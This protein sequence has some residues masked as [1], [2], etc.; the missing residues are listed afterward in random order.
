MRGRNRDGSPEARAAAR[1]RSSD[2][3]QEREREASERGEAAED[4]FLRTAPQEDAWGPFLVDESSAS[5]TKVGF[6]GRLIGPGSREES[7]VSADVVDGREVR[8]GKGDVSSGP[9]WSLYFFVPNADFGVREVERRHV[10][11]GVLYRLT[12]KGRAPLPP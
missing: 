1:S 11:N 5:L 3:G 12:R 7:S 10:R 8:V 6:E 4:L 2:L 9:G